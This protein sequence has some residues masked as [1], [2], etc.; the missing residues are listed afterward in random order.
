ML[1]LICLAETA[2]FEIKL[3]DVQPEKL[4][5]GWLE[6][7]DPTKEVLQ[8]ISKALD[9]PV[10]FLSLPESKNV[11][12]LRLEL[13]YCVINFLIIREIFGAKK[14]NP[15]IVIIS[16]NY[17]ITIAK[18]EDQKII[19]RAKE[20]LDKFRADQP[21]IAAFYVLDEI[22]G[23]HFVHLEQIEE[24][25]AHLEEE[26]VE[27]TEQTL[28]KRILRAKSRLTTFNKFLWYERGLVFNLKK[29]DAPYLSVKAKNS[30]DSTHEYLTR[31]I[32][33]VETYREILSDSINA[34]LSTVSN[35]IN[36][37]IRA[38]TAITLYLSVITTITSFPN[39]VATF[40]GISQFGNTSPA[41]IFIVL[42]LSII[43]PILWL[44]RRKWLK[45]TFEALKENGQ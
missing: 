27:K 43:L 44:W 30:F 24:L 39:T 45:T 21:S 12:N 7:V 25:A 28:V 13:D 26:V 34:Y 22:V 4:T 40:F 20:R 16:K 5:G 2:E 17:L 11:V 8:Q 38:L 32:D 33:I 9:I 36:F 37:S 29:S 1:R 15:I 42:V 3:E 41:I 23:D 19:D 18:N 14:I 6:I 10:G 31:Q 35:K